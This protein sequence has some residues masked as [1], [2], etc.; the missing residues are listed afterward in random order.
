V[1]T[2]LERRADHIAQKTTQEWLE[3]FR[4]LEILAAS[5]S[6]PASLFDDHHLSAVGIFF[7]TVDTLR[8]PVRFPSVP[9][10]FSRT[11]GRVAGPAN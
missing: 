7:Q 6:S 1:S 11:T 2:S 4:E 5:L 10:W 9:T 3:L 8:D